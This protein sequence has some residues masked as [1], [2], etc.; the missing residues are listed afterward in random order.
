M[1]NLTYGEA[2][3]ALKQGQRCT[4]Q[5]WNGKGMFVFMQVPAMVD[6]KYIPNMTSLPESVKTEFIKRGGNIHYTNQFAI[7]SPNNVINGWVASVSDTLA[8][9]WIIME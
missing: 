5:G 7:V 4:R 1:I 3:E 2:I 8:N 6:E 9:D